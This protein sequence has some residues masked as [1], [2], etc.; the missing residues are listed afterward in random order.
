MMNRPSFYPT[1]FLVLLLALVGCAPETSDPDEPTSAEMPEMETRADTVA[2]RIYE[3]AG[4][5]AA[6][7]AMPYLRFDFGVEREGEHQVVA[8]HLWNRQ[9][10]DYR[11]EWTSGPDSA[12][13]ALF[14]V[15][16]QEG[17]VYL[18][19]DSLAAGES[20]AQM[21]A[22]YRRYIN[23]SYWL[24]APVKLFDPGVN[25]AYV[26][27]SSSAEQEVIELTFGDVG[28][29][30]GDRYWIYADP[31]TGAMTAWAFVLQ[32]NP[33]AEPRMYRWTDVQTLETSEGPVTLAAAKEAMGSPV[34]LRTDNL[35]APT[36]VP[37]EMFTDPQPR[38]SD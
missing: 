27:D 5:P 24:L 38:L 2:M 18:N 31:E 21:E 3:A 34:V 30:P 12:Y 32:G 20:Q 26:A 6:M 9:T 16:S 19:G 7:A 8:R 22:A 1:L 23:D 4:G 37:A 35:E 28:L 17:D 15:N 33:D 25:R 10:G 13:V 36:D 29:T 11:V 14:N